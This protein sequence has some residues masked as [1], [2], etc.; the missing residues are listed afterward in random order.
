MK[1]GGRQDREDLAAE[2]AGRGAWEP[3]CEVEPSAVTW[4]YPEEGHVLGAGGRSLGRATLVA[5][6]P[7]TAGVWK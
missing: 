3:G 2:V 7:G 1:E 6:G 4:L 5:A